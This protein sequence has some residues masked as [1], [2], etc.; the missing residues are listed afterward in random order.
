MDWIL[1]PGAALPLLMS[2]RIACLNKLSSRKAIAIAAVV[3]P[4]YFGS[5][6]FISRQMDYSPH[7]LHPTLPRGIQPKQVRMAI[8]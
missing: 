6:L 2:Q 3:C 4:H 5:V 8:S 1:S 7:T